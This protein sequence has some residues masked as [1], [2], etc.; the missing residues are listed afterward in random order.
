MV[1]DLRIDVTVIRNAVMTSG[2]TGACLLKAPVREGSTRL[3]L[4]LSIKY[5]SFCGRLL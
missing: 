5:I 3:S 2:F 4:T 1:S